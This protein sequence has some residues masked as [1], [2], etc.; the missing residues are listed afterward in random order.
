MPKLVG[1]IDQGTS[2]TRFLLFDDVRCLLTHTERSS[3]QCSTAASPASPLHG[4][5]TYSDCAEHC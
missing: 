4:H 1:S 5:A 3:T 2:S